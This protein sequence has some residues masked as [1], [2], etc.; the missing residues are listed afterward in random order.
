MS[1]HCKHI[2]SGDHEWCDQP[3][4]P[5]SDYCVWHN[6]DLDKSD[7][8]VAQLLSSVLDLIHGDL[9]EFQLAELDWPGA[10]LSRMVLDGA[11]LRD[12]HLPRAQLVEASLRDAN[13]RRCNLRKANLHGANLSGCDLKHTDLGGADLSEANLSNAQLSDTNLMGANLSGANLANVNVQSFR[14]NDRTNFENV[15][16]LDAQDSD[17]DETQVFL[18]PVAWANYKKS[19]SSTL[20]HRD[21]VLTHEYRN[22]S[23]TLNEDAINKVAAELKTQS[24]ERR[25]SEQNLPPQPAPIIQAAPSTLRFPQKLLI[26]VS[27]A[28]ILIAVSA[29]IFGLWSFQQLQERPVITKEVIV[30]KEVPVEVPGN[31]AVAGDP[32]DSAEFK[33]LEQQHKQSLADLAQLREAYRASDLKLKTLEQE[34]LDQKMQLTRL[35]LRNDDVELQLHDYQQLK[36]K[37]AT[38]KRQTSRLKDTASIL[39]KGVDR[40]STE[41]EKLNELKNKRLNT[42]SQLELLQTKSLQ[43]QHDNDKMSKEIVEVR[44]QNQNLTAELTS[45][46][47]SLERFLSRIEGSRL[48]A[49][50]TN[51]A[52]QLKAIKIQPGKPIVLSGDNLITLEITPSIKDGYIHSKLFVQ[53]GA[54]HQMPDVNVIYYNA[55]M[56]ALR[57]IS[58]GFPAQDHKDNFAV[59]NAD[60]NSPAFPSF[61]RILVNP[62]V[63][64][65]LVAKNGKF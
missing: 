44:E 21:Q 20:T 63:E 53:R 23:S 26:G 38:L 55:Q 1:E 5:D 50:L 62:G 39:A 56:E 30:T 46:R 4:T 32:K 41:N 64:N 28:A 24:I 3:A 13:L 25:K 48:H 45:A 14:W 15:Q 34:K 57:S 43:L 19:Q 42:Q 49:F 40:L 17:S 29:V 54:Q 27:A 8:Y 36:Q 2:Y 59:S 47:K 12:A 22:A 52:S 18:T 37:Y 31:N 51:D 35:S 6:P 9:T 60:F 61:V 33:R 58:Y 11:N 10:E 7:A 16:G 65:E